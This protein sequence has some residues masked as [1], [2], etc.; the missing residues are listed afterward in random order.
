MTTSTARAVSA[1]QPI[2]AV[3]RLSKTFPGQR[4]VDEVTLD[5]LPG[6]VHALCGQ[7]GSGK[8]TLVKMLSGY[9]TPDPGGR[10]ELLGEPIQPWRGEGAARMHFIHQELGLIDSL[11]AVENLA[12]GHGYGTRGLKPIRWR[13]QR[14]EASR[15]FARLGMEVDLRRR[16]GELSAL[17]RTVVA[18]AR[19]LRSW[20]DD[21]GLLVLDEPTVSMPKPEVERLFQ[22]LREIKARGAGVLYVSHRLEEIFVVGDRVSVLRE[23]KLVFSEPV[24]RTTHDAV[25]QAI[26]GRYVEALDVHQKTD[27][28]PVALSVSGLVGNNLDG[29]SFEVRKGEIL[30]VTGLAGSGVDDL[31][32]TLFGAQPILGGTLE[33]HGRTV[34]SLTPRGAKKLGMALLPANR[35]TKGCIPTFSVREN[36]TLPWLR[37]LVTVLGV[38]R[39]RERAEVLRW[40]ERVELRPPLTELQLA[41]FSGGNQQK[42][43]IARWLRTAPEVLIMHEPTQG[44]DVGAK[45][46]IHQLLVDAASHGTSIVACSCDVVDLTKF[47]H[48]VL[49]LVNG[50]IAADLRGANVTDENVWSSLLRETDA[51]PGARRHE[52]GARV[53]VGG[54]IG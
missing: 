16:V 19:A 40:M 3:H 27:A 9:H 30:G 18:L 12:L 10:I 24:A 42:A 48:R 33:R 14:R 38:S 5:V 28:G 6:E 2:V 49:V 45:V 39:R 46:A 44:V 25:V 41:L 7:N 43:V 47:C 22:V 8:S 13:D 52:P 4:A 21:V 26:A 11:D 17:E 37:P 15:L 36:I 53:P 29:I 31:A 50:R 35:A 54:Q 20:A 34:R 1:P 23:G 32:E 51:S